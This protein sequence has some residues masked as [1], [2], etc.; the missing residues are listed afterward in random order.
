M[1]RPYD[2]PLLGQ[3]DWLAHGLAYGIQTLLLFV[4]A[5]GMMAI[6]RHAV[7]LAATG[8]T[9]FGTIVEFLQLLQPSRYFEAM[10]LLANSVGVAVAVIVLIV[11]SPPESRS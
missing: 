7:I 8:A 4:L 11:F 5:R 6:R 2:V 3:T 1:A 9:V 10:D